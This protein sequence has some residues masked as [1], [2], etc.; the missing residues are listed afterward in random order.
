MLKCICMLLYS[1]G[2]KW[3]LETT[4]CQ[5]QCILIATDVSRCKIKKV[6]DTEHKLVLYV[7][8]LSVVGLDI[9][10]TF[11]FLVILS[12]TVFAYPL[13]YATPDENVEHF[14]FLPS[15][16]I[17]QMN[18]HGFNDTLADARIFFFI[19]IWMTWKCNKT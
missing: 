7:S 2:Y 6:I 11:L 12:W 18:P 8:K 1:F 10:F 4:W 9:D 5:T 16:R 17:N 19:Y 15:H 13:C 3:C 14:V